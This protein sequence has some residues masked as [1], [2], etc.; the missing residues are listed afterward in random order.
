MSYINDFNVESILGI[1]EE[2]DKWRER[3]IYLSNQL[4][5]ILDEKE[6]LQKEIA[7]LKYILSTTNMQEVS[8]PKVLNTNNIR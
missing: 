1:V 7:R 2:R 8:V 6:N 5:K 3:A 4:N